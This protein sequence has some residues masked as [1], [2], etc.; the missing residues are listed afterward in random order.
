MLEFDKKLCVYTY[1]IAIV[2]SKTKAAHRAAFVLECS[3]AF[4]IED[5]THFVEAN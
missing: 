1:P 5:L 2:N 3:K 4:A